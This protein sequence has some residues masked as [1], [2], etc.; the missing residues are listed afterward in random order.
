M[1]TRSYR[2]GIAVSIILL[3]LGV[4]AA[5]ATQAPT[6]APHLLPGKVRTLQIPP[7]VHIFFNGTHG[8]HDWYVSNVNVTFTVDNGTIIHYIQYSINNGK[9]NFYYP[10][11]SIVLTT[12]D[13][14]ILS[15]DISDVNYTDWMDNFT[16]PIDKTPPDVT[17][18]K[19]HVASH[20]YK[21][22]AVVKDATSKAWRV[23]FYLDN[24]FQKNVTTAPYSWTWTGTA[25]HVVTAKAFDQAGNS[26]TTSLHTPY[27]YRPDPGAR[28]H[29]ILQLIIRL[30]ANLGNRL[31]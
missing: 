24:Q 4:T 13:V 26:A 6:P 25:D 11:T 5:A 22:T 9:W 8:S 23:E 18:N 15:V 16:V 1:T 30:L 12:E 31:T 21:F 19:R 28:L 20:Q 7:G 29:L 2:K 27:V 10:L 3:F 17:L 14:N